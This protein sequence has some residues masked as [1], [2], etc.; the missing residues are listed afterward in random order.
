MKL[1]TSNN[2]DFVADTLAEAMGAYWKAPDVSKALATITKLKGIGPA[3]ASLLLSVHD[4]RRV[5]FFSDEAF[6][7][8]CN[9]AK[10]C[11]I[12]YNAKEYRDLDTSAQRLVKRLGVSATNVEKVAFVLMRKEHGDIVS[13]RQE[14]PPPVSGESGNK[15]KFQGKRDEAAPL[16]LRRSKRGKT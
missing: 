1:V 7:W 4:P 8:L 9:D 16:Q 12:K 14:P 13:P 5:I 11:P 3:T 15:R 2:E 6:Y 10:P